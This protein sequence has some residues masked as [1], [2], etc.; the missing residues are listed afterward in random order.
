MNKDGPIVIVDD[1]TDDL[2]LL[3][4]IFRE[5]KIE[6]KVRLFPGGQEALEYLNK[7]SVRPFLV[8][9]DIYMPKMDGFELRNIIR[10][11]EELHIKCIP[12]LFF[13]TGASEEFVSRAYTLSVQGIFQKPPNYGKWKDIIEHIVTYWMYCMSPNRY[14]IQGIGQPSLLE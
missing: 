8:L 1:D 5:L 12:F 3:A 2:D 14:K 9:S 13:T 6:N 4:N 7:P 10:E 11:N